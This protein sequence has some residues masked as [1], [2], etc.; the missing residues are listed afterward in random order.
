ML[1]T[2]NSPDPHTYV[3]TYIHTT[4]ALELCMSVHIKQRLDRIL[5]TFPMFT[6]LVPGATDH[7]RS[8]VTV[9]LVIT[10]IIF[11]ASSFAVG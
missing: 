8:N 1:G 9:K 2:I 7:F 11:R 3:L 10:S 5:I 6:K 4:R